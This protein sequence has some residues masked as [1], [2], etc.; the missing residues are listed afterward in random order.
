MFYRIFI[1]INY[2][3]NPTFYYN[4]QDNEK[5]SLNTH[6]WSVGRQFLLPR[7]N[8]SRETKT[9]R[10]K[11]RIFNRQITFVGRMGWILRGSKFPFAGCSPTGTHTHVAHANRLRI[12]PFH[13]HRTINITSPDHDMTIEPTNRELLRFVLVQQIWRIHA[14]LVGLFAIVSDDGCCVFPTPE[15]DFVHR[16][17]VAF[18]VGQGDVRVTLSPHFDEDR[19][20]PYIMKRVD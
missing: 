8:W 1:S 11:K 6:K 18:F 9:K 10:E 16:A 20:A 19:A 3:K 13:D 4:F 7:M 12:L 2:K 14:H 5:P 15:H 17:R